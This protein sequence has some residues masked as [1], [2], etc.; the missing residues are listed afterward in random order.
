MDTVPNKVDHLFRAQLFH[1]R[2]QY[3]DRMSMTK[4]Q[5]ASTAFVD[6]LRPI[7][8]DA[9]TGHGGITATIKLTKMFIERGA[10][11]IHVEDQVC[12]VST[13]RLC[14]TEPLKGTWH[15]EMWS[16]GW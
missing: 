16:Y 4:E 11:G 6:Y 14:L 15:Q 2:K 1:D 10:A 7:V 9:D 5:R 8:A 13:R 3:Q 12:I